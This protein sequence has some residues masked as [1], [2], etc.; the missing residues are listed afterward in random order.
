MRSNRFALRVIAA[1]SVFGL[2]AAAC[3][4][5]GDGGGGG[6]EGGEKQTVKIAFF[7]ALTGDYKQLVIHAAQAAKMAFDQAN[8][9]KFG[10]LPVRIEFVE[11]D[12]QGSGDQASPL[13]D[14]V[15]ADPSFVGVIG[16]AFS[17]ESA[18][19]G[20]KFDQAAIPFVTPSATDD[21]LATHGW[22]HWFRG[23]GNNSDQ[24]KPASLYIQNVINPN[25]TFVASDGTA[26]GHGLA[27]IVHTVLSDAGL[28]VESE[29]Q[30]AP[31]QKDYSALVTKIQGAGCKTLFYGGYSPEAGLIRKQMSESGLDDV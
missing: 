15:V 13:A 4:G 7:G 25:C 12:T 8:E 29:E 14:K 16:P 19:T 10:D 6:G 11:Q 22:T 2:L 20:D 26:Y 30:V 17:G 18:A 31:A 1:V 3:G 24:A 28:Q 9:G 23:V 21:A 5:G 27:S